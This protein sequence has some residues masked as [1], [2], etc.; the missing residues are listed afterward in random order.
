VRLYLLPHLP[1]PSY[2][3]ILRNVSGYS[4]RHLRTVRFIRATQVVRSL[5]L[6]LVVVLCLPASVPAQDEEDA[7][8]IARNLFVD[9]GDHATSADLFFEFIRDYPVSERLPEARL[10]LAR[11]YGRSGRCGLAVRAYEEFY[12]NHPQ[13]LDASTARRERA[14]CLRQEGRHQ[15]AAEAFEEVQR[16]YSE[17]EFAAGALLDAAAEYASVGDLSAS[18]EL[19]GRILGKYDNGGDAL[20]AR[21]RLAQVLLAGGDANSALNLLAELETRAPESS[22]ARDGLLLSGRISLL[23]GDLEAA[24]RSFSRL[25][26]AHRGSAH[27]DSGALDLA[28]HFLG[29]GSYRKAVDAFTDAR[30]RIVDEKLRLDSHL[31]LADAILANGDSDK[32]IATYRELLETAAEADVVS[33]ARLGLAIAFGRADRAAAAITLFLE[34]IQAADGAGAPSSIDGA[35]RIASLRELGRLH[36]RQGNF[37]Q[38][39]TWF[40]RYLAEADQ[41]GDGPFP[42]SRL[43]RDEVRLQLADAYNAAGFS[44]RA[45]A[46]Y[47]HLLQSASPSLA[48][49]SQE[50]LSSA[51]E[52]AG[53]A[54]EALAEYRALLERFPERPGLGRVRDRIEYLSNYTVLDPG[55][56]SEAVLQVL[57]D[58]INGRPLR[59]A[60]LQLGHSLRHFH[61]YENA[62]RTFET[63]VASYGGD[64]WSWEAQYW[65]ADCLQRLSRQRHL[66]GIPAATDSLTSLA[67]QELRILAAA[68]AGA[69]S[70]R[71]RLRLIGAAAATEDGLDSL[72]SG[73]T[74][75]IDELTD[76]TD[77]DL[78]DDVAAEAMVQLADLRRHSAATDSARWLSAA[79]SYGE[80]LSR[81]PNHGLRQKARFGLAICLVG[82]G[83]VGAGLDSLGA[84]LQDLPSSALAS[85]VLFELGRGLAD[86]GQHR[87]AV[88]RFQELLLAYPAFA[89]RR[90]V[91]RKLADTHFLLEEYGQAA[92]LYQQL[93]EWSGPGADSE[94]ARR[95]L[96]LSYQRNGQLAEALA[97]YDQ[98]EQ[99]SSAAADS[100]SL[101]RGL[102]LVRVGRVD[103]ALDLFAS[104]AKTQNE[105]L[106]QLAARRAADLLFELGRFAEAYELYAPLVKKGTRNTVGQ[107]VVCLWRLDRAAEAKKAASRFAKR[108]DNAGWS[109]LF[110]IE[111]GSYYVR[112]GEI[113]RAVKHFE[114]VEGDARSVITESTV[115]S[116]LLAPL[117]ENPAAAAAYFSATAR[118]EANRRIPSQEGLARAL[119]AQGNFVTAYPDNPFV[120]DVRLRL[121]KFHLSNDNYLPAAGAFRHVL[122]NP[123]STRG[124]QEEAIWLRL[125]AYTKGNHFADAHT[126]AVTLTSQFPDHPESNAVQLEIGYI[127]SQMGQNA[128]AIQHFEGVLEWATGEDAAE[129]RFRIGE[130]YQNM[131]EY[132]TAII[133]YYDV[134]YRGADASSQWITSADFQRARCHVRLGEHP[135]A[136]SVYEKIIEQNGATSPQGKAAKAEIDALGT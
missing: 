118:W 59:E 100:I 56:R 120:A 38:A 30:Q 23:V 45:I 8:R 13:H 53:S 65:L 58:E 50:G 43:Q 135:T 31:G 15:L 32:A 64:I 33:R 111:E 1:S 103:E 86:T 91:R 133:K 105:P 81:F 114:K 87:R 18:I 122:D 112:L 19:Y 71:A 52:K 37:K 27:A 2:C 126:T 130:A 104:L 60:R 108:F 11:S 73:L 54:R 123:R 57:L 14:S 26:V 22:Q 94:L 83:K 119:K 17:S 82:Q 29:S 24:A 101:E 98:L 90:I 41:A 97:V 125:R 128:L 77:S 55:K 49:A 134:S 79:A 48:A 9:A 42:E 109:L 115:E 40:H 4:A 131:G 21:L 124:Q 3:L 69:W 6:L 95:R 67:Q 74:A 136:I 62:A 75:L 89:Q 46:E 10:M 20:S 61:D 44:E 93:A 132:R 107:S 34:L 96:A 84:L 127:L 39:I 117:I 47:R 28:N 106:A 7:F 116:Q 129:A 80:F 88:T 36:R 63:Y 102:L 25:H 16:L 66:E 68:D 72:E 99:E 85:E 51:Y 76:A 110:R 70:Y 78:G 12:Q 5:V 92:R 121:G 113:D 35:V